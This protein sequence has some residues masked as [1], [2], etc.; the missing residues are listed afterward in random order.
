[1]VITSFNYVTFKMEAKIIPN[2]EY[3]PK[4]LQN[5]LKRSTHRIAL[6]T[7][8]NGI[9]WNGDLLKWQEITDVQIK[10]FNGNP[11]VQL[12]TSMQSR[13]LVSFFFPSK[14]YKRHFKPWFGASPFLT[15]EFLKILDEQ[16]QKDSQEKL[17]QII[18]E[19]NA[20]P[21]IQRIW[22]LFFWVFPLSLAIVS[23]Y[24]LI[25]GITAGG[26]IPF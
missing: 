10:N 13:P 4:A 12:S 14:W 21:S 26:T 7:D 25:F 6:K 20:N 16:T 24:I 2:V 18:L 19:N 15:L 1:M 3:S 9:T 22:N 8:R 5:G 23:I 17:E 11:Y